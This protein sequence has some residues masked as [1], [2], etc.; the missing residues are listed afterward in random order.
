MIIAQGCLRLATIKGHS[1]M[2][3]FTVLGGSGGV[4]KPVSI[5]QSMW[6]ERWEFPLPAHVGVRS[7]HSTAQ[8][9]SRPLRSIPLPA[10]LQFHP[11]PVK[12]LHARSHLKFLCMPNTCRFQP[13]PYAWDTL[14]LRG[15]RGAGLL[16]DCCGKNPLHFYSVAGPRLRCGWTAPDTRIFRRQCGRSN[17]LT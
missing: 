17:L 2:C 6:A 9:R 10:H 8:S 1:K 12:S 14:S 15:G 11:T 3:T 5:W 16:R 7:P 4:R 13:K